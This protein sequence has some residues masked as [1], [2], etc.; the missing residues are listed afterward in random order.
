MRLNCVDHYQSTPTRFDPV[1]R[2]NVSASQLVKE[3]KVPV[4]RVFGSTQTGQKV[5]AHIHGAFPYLYIE[6]S[7]SLVPDEGMTTAPNYMLFLIVVKLAHTFIDFIFQSIMR[8][9]LVTAGTCKMEDRD[10]WQ[11]SPSSRASLS[12]A[13]MWATVTT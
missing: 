13:F 6:Y 3:P 9:L 10:L 5:C 4:I 11:E 7:G 8:L 12:T 1:L 2:N